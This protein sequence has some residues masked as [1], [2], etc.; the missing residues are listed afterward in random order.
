[1]RLVLKNKYNELSKEEVMALVAADQEEY[2]TNNRLQQLLDTHAIKG[3]KILSLLVDKGYLEPDGIGRGTK[4]YLTELFKEGVT[5]EDSDKVDENS[6]K[7][8]SDEIR[9]LDF[10]KENG[11]I[12]NTLSRTE[13]EIKK[14]RSVDLFNSLLSKNKIKRTGN[15]NKVKYVLAEGSNQQLSM[16]ES[17]KN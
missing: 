7:L 9:I 15:G 5:I 2:I 13:L 17:N 3:N 12:T 10:I 16:L 11:Y 14:H 4:Y 8:S 6:I 1:M